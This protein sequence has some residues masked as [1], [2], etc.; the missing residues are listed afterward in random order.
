M[1]KWKFLWKFVLLWI[2][3]TGIVQSNDAVKT[4]AQWDFEEKEEAIGILTDKVSPFAHGRLKGK[5]GI[6]PV[7]VDFDGSR[8]LFF[9]GDYK[10]RVEIEDS[11][12]KFTKNFKDGLIIEAKFQVDKVDKGVQTIFGRYTGGGEPSSYCLFIHGNRLLF[13]IISDEDDKEYAL[14]D[15]GEVMSK[16]VYNVKAVF[17][18]KEA[19]EIYVNGKLS[20][21]RETT[22][23]KLKV[24]QNPTEAPISIGC[25]YWKNKE[26]PINFFY[27][28]ID[29]IVVKEGTIS[30][31]IV[32]WSYDGAYQRD[33]GFQGEIVLNGV[34]YWQ[35]YQEGNDQPD[36]TIWLYRNVP[37]AGNDFPVMTKTG[38]KVTTWKKQKITGNEKCWQEREFTVPEKWK[39]REIFVEIFNALGGAEV[40]LDGKKV[41]YT[42]ENLPAKLSLPKPINYNKPYKLTILS[43]GIIDDVWLRSFPEGSRIEETYLITSYR[44]KN[45]EIKVK[46]FSQEKKILQ[47]RAVV[48]ETPDFKEIT[49]QFGPAP[50]SWEKDT[51]SWQATITGELTPDIKL[52]SRENPNLY[53]YAVELVDEK[54]KVVD[55][56]LPVRTGFREFWIEDGNFYLNGVPVYIYGN[57]NTSFS[58]HPSRMALA[59]NRQAIIHTADGWRRVGLNSWRIGGRGGG[60]AETLLDVSDEMGFIVFLDAQDFND[61]KAYISEPA[62]SQ[63]LQ[64][65]LS[66]S[67]RRYRHHPSLGMWFFWSSSAGWTDYCPAAMDGSIDPYTVYP[68]LKERHKLTIEAMKL[69]N[70]E[71]PARPLVFNSGGNCGSVWTSMAYM[72][73]DVE[74]QERE[75]W[76]LVWS[77]V[78]HKPVMPTEHG[79]PMYASW[80]TRDIRS[81][82]PKK[83]SQFLSL[84]YSAMYF[85]D[86]WYREEPEET[87]LKWL[88]P[89]GDNP[90]S[91]F[92]VRPPS[93]LDIQSLFAKYTIRAWRTYGISFNLHATVRHFYEKFTFPEFVKLDPR[94]PGAITDV[95]TAKNWQWEENV[96]PENILGKTVRETLQSLYVYIGGPDGNFTLKDHAY[97]SGEKV[98]KSAIVINDREVPVELKGKWSVLDEKGK[99]ITSGNMS[100]RVSPGR[101]LITE[102]PIQFTAPE[103]KE[104]KNYLLRISFKAN[105]PGRLE[106]EFHFQVFP[107][108]M[109][110][111]MTAGKEI[112]CYDPIGE[113]TELLNKMGMNYKKIDKEGSLSDRELLVIGRH[114]LEKEENVKELSE[115]GFDEAVNRGLKVLVFEQATK[116]MLG[117]KLEETSTRH[118]FIRSKNHPVLQGLREEDFEYWKGESNLV[119][120]F[121]KPDLALREN[122]EKFWKWGNDNIVATYVIEKPQMGAVRSIIDSGFDLVE[123][124]L[125]EIAKGRGRMIF[126]Q[127]DVTNRYGTDPV[128]TKV[129]DNIFNYLSEVKQPDENLPEPINLL[130]E[131]TISIPIEEKEIL[132]WIPDKEEWGISAA[133]CFFREK[134]KLPVIQK[135][136]FY[137]KQTVN[138][139]D[140][141]VHTLDL[142]KFKTS[143]QKSKVLRVIAALRI[144]QGGTSTVGP[145]TDIAQGDTITLYPINWMEGFVHPYSYWRW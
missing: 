8:G 85:G 51:F 107:K 14:V 76:P 80:Y 28:T 111:K 2:L 88:Y 115:M 58:T 130:L 3:F 86:K 70:E 1:K 92:F 5:D 25:R 142:N 101:R 119:E 140:I 47:V 6:K 52:W 93:A 65:R 108:E 44:K 95:S 40:F 99:E 78:R 11:S 143:W 54:G 22:I 67:I 97:Y 34:W 121:E 89:I 74:L 71:D 55:K 43:N 23:E 125:L 15:G 49:K 138:G 94:Q 104:R 30:S 83:G 81:S 19:I 133:D 69:V 91:S 27:G 109:D 39:D 84:E 102:L 29:N 21:R 123:T 62:V 137:R 38:G 24:P 98:K 141:Y 56:S 12:G 4:I 59:G 145:S 87:I 7:F 117:L 75:N 61:Q 50:I 31:S 64:D 42:W 114:A 105:S 113:T 20:G 73:F 18:P 45:V 10:H 96:G 33:N 110:L 26:A 136:G 9:D 144:N 120:A 126:C 41:G 16:I 63:Y 128:A 106:D 72:G 135:N 68:E 48:S 127:L 100:A 77:K 124:P 131:K 32:N 103:V 139:K 116:S 134:L 36:S 132:R 82:Y 60:S 66:C 13:M 122:P 53:W 17:I 37:G 57:I 112:V 129:V 46:G 79:F 35:P 118:T 90:V